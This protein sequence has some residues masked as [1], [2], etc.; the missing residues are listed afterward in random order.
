L[1]SVNRLP[2]VLRMLVTGI[3]SYSAGADGAG[4]PGR[5]EEPDDGDFAAAEVEELEEAADGLYFSISACVVSL[6]AYNS[7]VTAS[8]PR[9]HYVP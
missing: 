6:G 7:I 9:T 5:A 1:L 2:I 3:S 8:G 4:L